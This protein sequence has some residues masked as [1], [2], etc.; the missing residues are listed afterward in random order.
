MSPTLASPEKVAQA[1]TDMSAGCL[2]LVTRCL[3]LSKVSF[4][5]PVS[6]ASDS[7]AWHLRPLLDT[8]SYTQAWFPATFVHCHLFL[9]V[10]WHNILLVA[11]LSDSI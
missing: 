10:C 8:L 11:C 6:G 1:V 5:P 9:S 7:C 2:P 4:T 3:G